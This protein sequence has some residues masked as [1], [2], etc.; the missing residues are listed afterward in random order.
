[1]SRFLCARSE[2]EE[3]G[4]ARACTRCD[5]QGTLWGAGRAPTEDSSACAPPIEPHKCCTT[6]AKPLSIR[7]A[8]VAS[9]LVSPGELVAMQVPLLSVVA[10]RVPRPEIMS[11]CPRKRGTRW[12]AKMAVK[13]CGTTNANC[14]SCLHASSWQSARTSSKE[15]PLQSEGIV[16]LLSTSRGPQHYHRWCHVLQDLIW[17]VSSFTATAKAGTQRNQELPGLPLHCKGSAIAEPVDAALPTQ[18]SPATKASSDWWRTV[19]ES[20]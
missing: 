16:L 6:T 4:R 1:M 12:S 18:Y 20:R 13:C 5:R 15:V 14:C 19:E 3:V 10:S 2:H 8:A 17:G 9:A 7:S 11:R